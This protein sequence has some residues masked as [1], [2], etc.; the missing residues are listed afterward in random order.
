MVTRINGETCVDLD[1][2]SRS[3]RRGVIALRLHSGPMTEVRFRNFR[4]QCWTEADPKNPAE[5]I[6]PRGPERFVVPGGAEMLGRIVGVVLACAL[7]GGGVGPAGDKLSKEHREAFVALAE[8]ARDAK[9]ERRRSAVR[10]LAEF[11]GEEAWR[12]VFAAL[13]DADSSV[14]DAGRR[15]IGRLAGSQ[16]RV[17]V[18]RAGGARLEGRTRAVARGGG[19]RALLQVGVDAEQL[20]RELSP[21]GGERDRLLVWSIERLAASGGRAATRA[22]SCAKLERLERAD[23]DKGLAGAALCALARL[24]RPRRSTLRAIRCATA[25]A[26]NA[27]LRRSCWGGWSHRMRSGRLCGSLRT[28]MR[29]CACAASSASMRSGTRASMLAIVGRLASEPRLRACAGVRSTCCGARRDS[30]TGSTRGRGSFGRGTAR[31]WRAAT[32]DVAGGGRRRPR[33]GRDACERFCGALDSLGPRRVP[34]RLLRVHVDADGRRAHPKD[35]VDAKLGRL[36]LEAL[37]ESTEFNLI[38]FTNVPIP[39]A[40]EARTAKRGEVEE[41]AG[42]VL[43]VPREGARGNFFDAG[44]IAMVD[45][46]IDTIV[47]LTD[48]VPTG[49]LHS[50]MDLIVAL[51]AERARTRP[52]VIDSILVDSPPGTAKR[53]RDLAERT[54]GRS[55]EVDLSLP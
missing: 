27:A 6:P 41:G 12:L 10:A 38:P 54:G 21:R 28:R 15:A 26:T 46:A 18:V 8:Q 55:I 25:T 42:V 30:S 35:I 9:P 2:P 45:P 1:E 49:G 47:V 50:E 37:P 53:W 33:P 19:L 17:G 22:R 40:P 39:Y 13:E 16:A 14:G 51:L 44:A 43:Q 24:R 5:V 11:G 31:R 48:G 36:A 7:R 4:L 3:A 29:A 34:V 32:R 20:A 23:G 52:I